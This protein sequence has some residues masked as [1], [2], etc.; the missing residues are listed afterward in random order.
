FERW[1]YAAGR[2]GANSLFFL[3]S[4]LGFGIIS[5][6]MPFHTWLIRL[7]AAL[8]RALGGTVVGLS[9][10]LGWY[11]L[12]RFSAEMV[13]VRPPW[14]GG[15]LLVVGGGRALWAGIFSL[16]ERELKRVLAYLSSAWAGLAFASLGAGI[17]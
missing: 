12:L 6:V 2:S 15:V 16:F 7:S 5:G 1:R 3:L 14:W 10:A 8:P 13:S 11:G 9:P 4:L 17:L